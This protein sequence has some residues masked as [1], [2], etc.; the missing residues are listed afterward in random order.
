MRILRLILNFLQV[1]D[2][3]EYIARELRF[4]YLLKWSSIIPGTLM[5]KRTFIKSIIVIVTLM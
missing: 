1:I 3:I 2:K 4:S 5:L